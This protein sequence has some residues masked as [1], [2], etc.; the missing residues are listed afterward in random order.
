MK[1]NFLKV[2]LF[3]FVVTIGSCEAEDDDLN[4]VTKQDFLKSFSAED[5]CFD[6]D[7]GFQIFNGNDDT[8][9]DNWIELDFL[10]FPYEGRSGIAF[11]IKAQIDGNTMTMQPSSGQPAFME[12]GVLYYISFNSGSGTLSNGILTLSYEYE[13]SNNPGQRWTCT[14]SCSA[15]PYL[16]GQAIL[17]HDHAK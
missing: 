12:D 1:T 3:S 2:I 9:N 17:V 7:H 16:S 13:V 8:P 11:Q 6:V 5:D 14:A 15:N 10:N 4:I